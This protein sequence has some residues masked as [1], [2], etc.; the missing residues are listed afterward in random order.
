M[1]LLVEGTDYEVVGVQR[2]DVYNEIVIRTINTVDDG[3]TIAVDL[4][5]YGISATG[6]IGAIGFE[7]TTDNSVVVQE[8]PT[9]SVSSGTVTLAVGG[10]N[11]NNPRHLFIRGYA[12]PN[13]TSA[14]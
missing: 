2:G 9:T 12:D 13:P 5:K 1:G 7:H 6:L 10:S 11:D 3:D 4:T 8:N 14:L